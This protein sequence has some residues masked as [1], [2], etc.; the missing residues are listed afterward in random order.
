MMPRLTTFEGVTYGTSRTSR[1]L[2]LPMQTSKP[3]ARSRLRSGL[4][5][6][7]F[8]DIELHPILDRYRWAASH[9]AAA[10]MSVAPRDCKEG[11]GWN[12]VEG[13]GHNLLERNTRT[14]HLFRATVDNDGEL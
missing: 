13:Q 5:L 12:R 1:C 11:V 14:W 9:Q 7:S 2:D 8:C 6:T 10:L 4:R 3:S